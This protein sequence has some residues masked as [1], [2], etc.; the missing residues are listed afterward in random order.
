MMP[1]SP[2][3]LI[4]KNRI[5]DAK[6]QIRK[7]AAFNKVPFKEEVLENLQE[8][9]TGKQGEPGILTNWLSSCSLVTMSLIICFNWYAKVIDLQEI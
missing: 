7:M 9:R 3:W 6:A 4:S 5:E 2:R 1:E 8:E